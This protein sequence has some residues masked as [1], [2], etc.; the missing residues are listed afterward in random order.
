MESSDRIGLVVKD[1]LFFKTIL[2]RL[3]DAGCSMVSF[4]HTDMN[5]FGNKPIVKLKGDFLGISNL[6]ITVIQEATIKSAFT[7]H[8]D[9]PN[10]S[11][12][13]ALKDEY[14]KYKRIFTNNYGEPQSDESF[15]YP[16]I[17]GD[18]R[19][20]EALNNGKCNYISKFCIDKIQIVMYIDDKGCIHFVYDGAALSILPFF[21][22]AV[23]NTIKYDVNTSVAGVMLF[24]ETISCKSFDYIVKCLTQLD[25]NIICQLDNSVSFLG[26][27]DR[28]PNCKIKVLQNAINESTIS[29]IVTFPQQEQWTMLKNSYLKYKAIFTEKYGTPESDEFF[30]ASYEE[31]D[32]M[33]AL[34]A[35]SCTYLSSFNTDDTDVLL[36]IGMQGDLRIQYTGGVSNTTALFQSDSGHDIK[37][38]HAGRHLTFKGV[39][40]NGT[41]DEVVEQLCQKGYKVENHIDSK[42]SLRGEFAGLSNCEIVVQKDALLDIVYMVAAFFV[43]D[44][45]WDTLKDVYFKYK[46]IYSKKYGVPKSY[47]FFTSPFEDGEGQELEALK[48]GNCT[49]LSIYELENGR[50]IVSILKEGGVAAIYTDKINSELV[51][52]ERERRAIMD[53]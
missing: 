43:V 5:E 12:W 21:I 1:N 33:Q 11:Q 27:F 34:K 40:I 36:S 25:Y 52:A 23:K 16:F 44:D 8:V 9:L 2:K 53:I 20:M 47:E 18:G 3:L 32:E 30:G 35:G 26:E 38:I 19:E 22:D 45:N 46:D 39:E 4:Y 42:I 50:I 48:T 10:Q 31:G 41:L 37:T 15:Y 6:G 28:T 14:S 29:I 49:Y 13:A 7:I 17:D 51:E 24:D